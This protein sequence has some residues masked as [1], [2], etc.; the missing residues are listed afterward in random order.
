MMQRRLAVPA[1]LLVIAAGCASPR[2]DVDGLER[3]FRSALAA[4]EGTEVALDELVRAEWSTVALFGP[5]TPREL[6]HRCL[7]L[8]AGVLDP[9]GIESRDDVVLLVF[10]FAEGDHESVAITRDA[11]DFG[12]EAVGSQ[13]DQLAARFVVRAPPAGSWGRLAPAS[14]ITWRC[15]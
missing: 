6:I 12:P 11:A 13:Y 4:G 7:D 14:G 9:H 1:L 3:G 2:V 10:R 15:T 5:Y 8:G